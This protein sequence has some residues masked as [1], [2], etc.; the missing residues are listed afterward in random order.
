MTDLSHDSKAA[1]IVSLPR[2]NLAPP[3]RTPVEVLVR[4]RVYVCVR[5]VCYLVLRLLLGTA[6]TVIVHA[7]CCQ[8]VGAVRGAVIVESCPPLRSSNNAGECCS[9]GE[10]RGIFSKEKRRGICG[11]E[12][13]CGIGPR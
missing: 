1:D 11:T 12:E 2:K 6:V 8:L 9:M 4:V 3:S 13:S 5:H 7:L 10:R